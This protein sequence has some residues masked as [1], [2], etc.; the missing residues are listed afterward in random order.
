MVK[1]RKKAVMFLTFGLIASLSLSGCSGKEREPEQTKEAEW[2]VYWYLCGSDLESKHGAASADISELLSIRPA[3]GVKVVVQTGGAAE[4]KMAEVNP[5]ALCRFVYDEN[6]W[7]KLEECEEANMGAAET[8]S[9]F[10]NYCVTNHPAKRTMVILWNH[11]GGVLGGVAYDEKHGLDSL[12]VAEMRTAFEQAE[13]ASFDII[14]FDACLMANI[15]TAYAVSPFADYMIASQELEP[16]NGWEYS[17][18]LKALSENPE[19]SPEELGKKVCDSFMEGCIAAES[20]GE[21]TLSL[22]DLSHAQELFDGYQDCGEETFGLALEDDSLFAAYGRAAGEAEGYGGNSKEEGYTN[23]VDMGGI[24][25]AATFLSDEKKS[26]INDA[27]KDCVIYQVRGSY[28]AYGSG[29]SCY[30]PLDNGLSNLYQFKENS[31][32]ESYEN[33]YQYQISGKLNSTVLDYLHRIGLDVQEEGKGHIT[34]ENLG[35]DQ[36]PVNVTS[37]G[38]MVLELGSR[39][40]YLTK[41]GGYLAWADFDEARM[42]GI[43]NELVENADWENGV[44]SYPYRDE[45]WYMDDHLLYTFFLE[46]RED[47]SLYSVPILLNGENMYLRMAARND[48][49]VE[50]LGAR[51]EIS[52]NAMAD[53]QLTKLKEG[54]VVTTR[55]YQAKLGV[56]DSG[57]ALKEYETFTVTGEPKVERK[58]LMDGIYAWTY[59]MKD[60]WNQYATSDLVLYEIEDGRAIKGN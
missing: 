51:K 9:D 7:E 57:L 10:L 36:Y 23:M 42:L 5:D 49:T 30:Y 20:D 6:G 17:G 28:R 3:S 59:D 48:G 25:K 35:L 8:L 52:D 37:D 2:A 14:G 50:I 18:I 32:F 22:L 1:K 11:G 45:W 34:V 40:R 38:N 46:K 29:V 43:G 47:Y 13:N 16:G 44:F 21:A 15:D 56:A 19:I 54:D 60:M 58:P 24:M 27:L 26:E 53:K 33:L 4:W 31:E 39:A 55:F 12:S 41:V